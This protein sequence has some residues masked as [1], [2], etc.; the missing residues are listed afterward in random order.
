MSALPLRCALCALPLLTCAVDTSTRHEETGRQADPLVRERVATRMDEIAAPAQ[1]L[2]VKLRRQSETGDCDGV[3]DMAL[4][5][6]K[7]SG[8]VCELAADFPGDEEIQLKC[9]WPTADCDE[10]EASCKNC[11]GRPEASEY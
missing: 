2:H 11:G 4:E 7:A 1:R 8:R 5:V 3:C 9:Q 6:C 10:A